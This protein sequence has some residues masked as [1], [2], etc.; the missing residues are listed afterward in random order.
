MP[1][2]K[3]EPITKTHRWL[4]RHVLQYGADA[5]VIAPAELR[6]VVRGERAPAHFDR[7]DPCRCEDAPTDGVTRSVG[8]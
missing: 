1:S 7:F 4:V 8:R 6:A 2:T 3:P 5:E